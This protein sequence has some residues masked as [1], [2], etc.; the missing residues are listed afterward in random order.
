[1]RADLFV[2]VATPV[3]VA[4]LLSVF[5]F[6]GCGHETIDAG[7]MCTLDEARRWGCQQCPITCKRLDGGVDAEGDAAELADGAMGCE[8]ECALRPGFGWYG[9]L[10]VSLG[11]EGEVPACPEQAQIA[12]DLYTDLV[13]SPASCGACSCD[14]PVGS[15]T[16]PT[17]MIA[18]TATCAGSPSGTWFSPFDAPVG[19]DGSCTAADALA[20]GCDGVLCIKSLTID[21]LLVT[22]G[23]CTPTM[24][25]PAGSPSKPSWS[26]FA[27][28]CEGTPHSGPGGCE[29]SAQ[30]CVPK[31]APGFAQ[32]IHR[33]GN[34]PCDPD[35][36][37]TERHVLYEGYADT[38]SC[39]A[40]A[41]GEATGSS[42]TAKVSIFTSPMCSDLLGLFPIDAI[43]PKC[44]DLP[45]GTALASKSAGPVLHVPGTCQPSGGDPTGSVELLFPTTFCCAPG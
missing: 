18:S 2:V 9:P 19:W 15:C 43:G 1:M 28:V 7:R 10:L 6:A 22:E 29:S 45:P 17:D 21:P 38:R 33:P 25:G 35:Q 36:P 20:A 11:A 14:P 26:T 5:L 27:R 24:T 32:C 34:F 13:V 16:L 40:C 8:G 12:K 31:V 3:F 41:C 23:G 30:T 4:G 44:F 39:S 37:Y 42:C